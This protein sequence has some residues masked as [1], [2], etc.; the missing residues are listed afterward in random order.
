VHEEKLVLSAMVSGKSYE[1]KL[2]KADWPSRLVPRP[3]GA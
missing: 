1:A 3:R 2:R